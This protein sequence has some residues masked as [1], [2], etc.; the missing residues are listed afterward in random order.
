MSLQKSNRNECSFKSEL[1][2][3]REVSAMLQMHEM[4]VYRHLNSGK[5]R[6]LKVGGSWRVRKQDVDGMFK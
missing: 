2:T 1:M 6:G 3:L 4:T 5:I